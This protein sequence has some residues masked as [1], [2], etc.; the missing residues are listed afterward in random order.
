M[1]AAE[2]RQLVC[3]RRPALDPALDQTDIEQYASYNVTVAVSERGEHVLTIRRSA[4]KALP[5]SDENKPHMRLPAVYDDFQILVE[6][7]LL[8]KAA[9][10]AP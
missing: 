3:N 7:D 8:E 1:T 4:G 2:L 5:G 6:A 10:L 9:Q